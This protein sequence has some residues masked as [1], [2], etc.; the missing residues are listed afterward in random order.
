MTTHNTPPAMTHDR[1]ANLP[2]PDRLQPDQVTWMK[3]VAHDREG[4]M[5]LPQAHFAQGVL[6]A[7]S[8]VDKSLATGVPVSQ[9]FLHN[10]S[11]NVLHLRLTASKVAMHEHYDI[12]TTP[13]MIS[14]GP[15]HNVWDTDK[16][17][18]QAFL[19]TM[20]EVVGIA[21]QGTITEIPERD[22][23]HL[24]V[25]VSNEDAKMLNEAR[26]DPVFQ[27][28]VRAAATGLRS[29]EVAQ[30]SAAYIAEIVAFMKKYTEFGPL[31]Y[32][33]AT[34]RTDR[35]SLH[36][37]MNSRVAEAAEIAKSNMLD[38]AYSHAFDIP[39]LHHVISTTSTSNLFHSLDVALPHPLKNPDYE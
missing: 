16:G 37:S 3:I 35:S 32:D 2:D 31:H 19:T 30:I 12:Q 34:Y 7:E 24:H 33:D 39:L 38:W 21:R 14:G 13:S 28:L 11:Q 22:S 1:E 6:V 9:F 27:G 17:N 15:I 4:T 26:D 20:A 25:H 29:D 10:P 23:W 8:I 18:A 36:T 5:L